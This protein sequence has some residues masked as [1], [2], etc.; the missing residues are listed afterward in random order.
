MHG[1]DAIPC[2]ASPP[3]PQP[4][5]PG[6]TVPARPIPACIAVLL[7]T[8]RIMLGFG[9]HLAETAMHRSASSDFNAIAACFGTSRLHVI[10]AH[11]QRGLL[12]ATA[13]ERLLLARAASGRDIRFVTPRKRATT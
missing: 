8:V 5:R 9:R 7:Q 13:L 3:D 10:L 1:D 12:R 11:L 2:P 4:D 6:R